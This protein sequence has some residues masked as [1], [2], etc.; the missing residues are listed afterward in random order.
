MISMRYLYWNDKFLVFI[1]KTYDRTYKKNSILWFSELSLKIFYYLSWF[2]RTVKYNENFR[3]RDEK[4]NLK[5]V[6]G[7]SHK[8]HLMFYF[9]L[10]LVSQNI[11]LS[12]V[13]LNYTNSRD[14]LLY[15]FDNPKKMISGVSIYLYLLNE[16]TEDFW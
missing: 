5:M 14:F 4:V 12:Y 7:D 13:I 15:S 10:Y 2:V 16:G 1:L 3:N 9:F 6:L 11:V 8:K